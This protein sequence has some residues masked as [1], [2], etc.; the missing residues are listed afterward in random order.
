MDKLYVVMPAYNEEAN[1][2]DVVKEWYQVLEGKDEGSRLV[3]ADGGSKDNT[4][5]ILYDLQKD[6][7]KLEVFSKPD[8]DHGTKL[9][10]LYDYAIKQK[11]DYIFQTDSDG[12]TNPE[13]FGQFWDLRC[14]YD[15]IL[16]DRSD[17]ED[18]KSR[19]LVENVLRFVLWI[20]FGAKT[21]DANAPFRLMKSEL[22]AKYLYKMPV[23]FNLPNAILAA[24][25]SKFNEKV[26]YLYVSFRPRQGGK[27]YMNV[28]RIIKIGWDSIGNFM[29]LRKEYSKN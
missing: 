28:K 19:V 16:G 8:T 18:G 21:P 17:R 27:N 11:A 13:E 20:F 22:V 23:D 26:K 9:I 7:S 15:A 2:V 12:Q 3:I 6:Y 24:C 5:N 25:F 10:F 14:E 29:K 1:I 4:L